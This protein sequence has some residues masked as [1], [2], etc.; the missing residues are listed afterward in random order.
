MLVEVQGNSVFAGCRIFKQLH[1]EVLLTRGGGGESY[2]FFRLFYQVE[3]L[4]SGMHHPD[5]ILWIRRPGSPH[6]VHDG[7][8]GLRDIAPT[9]LQAFGVQPPAYMTGSPLPV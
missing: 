7:K 2:P 6:C 9:L 4:K 5:G 8:V 3:G 1:H